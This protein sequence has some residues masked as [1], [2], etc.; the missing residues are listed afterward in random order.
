MLRRILAITAGIAVF[1]IVVMLMDSVSHQLHPMPHG[2]DPQDHGMMMQHMAAAPFGVMFAVM[3]GWIIGTLA[4]AFAAAK[5]STTHKRLA[6]GIVG[7]LAFAGTTMNVFMLPHPWW[8]IVGGLAGIA[9]AA[10]VGWKLGDR[11]YD[12]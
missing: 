2:M 1:T 4:G 3:L 12:A 9:V 6:A 7:A 5:I 8:M 10:H 11:G